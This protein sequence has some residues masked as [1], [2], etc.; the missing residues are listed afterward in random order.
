[1]NIQ[2]STFNRI[3][4]VAGLFLII[5]LLGYFFIIQPK[6]TQVKV[7]QAEIADLQAQYAELKRVAD[8]KPLYLAFEKAIRAR[9]TGVEVTAVPKTYI[10]SYLKQIENLAKSDGL[11]VV[12][13]SP[14]APPPPAPG[15]SPTPAANITR[16]PAAIQ[17]LVPSGITH[18]AGV[19]ANRNLEA[20]PRPGAAPGP[21]VRPPGV[22]QVAGPPTAREA[23]LSYLNQS[24]TQVPVN[25]ELSG[26]YDQFE[27]FLR[28]LSKFPK[29]IGVGDV[30][31]SSNSMEVGVRP[32]LKIVVPVT[33]Y[34]LS[35]NAPPGPA[36][37]AAPRPGGAQ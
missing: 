29:L 19:E 22:P 25:M 1:M 35:P 4:I 7:T 18:A 16:P 20:S 2:L 28:D 14:A 11:D 9:L 10:P 32:R 13:V 31:L 17:Q 23:A 8:Q 36:A 30:T 21:G 3:I 24:F 34:R 27:K 12:S 5:A 26:R 6:T 33:A 37:P 15:A